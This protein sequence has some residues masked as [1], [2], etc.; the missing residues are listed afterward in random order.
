MADEKGYD[1][2]RELA[3]DALKKPSRQNQIPLDRPQAS[4]QRTPSVRPAPDS[5]LLS[6]STLYYRLANLTYP[7]NL[8][9]Q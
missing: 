4:R 1:K 5:L 7:I 6:V 8:A 9:Y 2:A 3:E